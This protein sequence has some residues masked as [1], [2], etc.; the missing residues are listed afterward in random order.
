[1]ILCMTIYSDAKKKSK[2]KENYTHYNG[3]Q[4]NYKIVSFVEDMHVSLSSSVLSPWLR[5]LQTFN[6]IY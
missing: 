1:M 3:K 4:I 6:I 2:H 5:Q